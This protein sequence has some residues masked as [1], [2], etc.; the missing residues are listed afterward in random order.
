MPLDASARLQIARTDPQM[1]SW[2]F[3]GAP[4][5]EDSYLYQRL[6]GDFAK[7]EEMLLD[8]QVRGKI[9]ERTGALLGRS[10]LVDPAFKS[11]TDRKAADVARNLIDSNLIPY[12]RICAGFLTSGL[13]IGFAVQAVTGTEEKTVYLPLP[14]KEGA[15]EDAEPRLEKQKVIVPLLETVPQRRFTFRYHEPEQ[16]DV[17][18]AGGA[19]TTEAK[20]EY[21]LVNGYELRLL[22]RRAPV[23]GERCPADRF[24]VF[25][26]GSIK[27][28]PQGFGLGSMIRK[29]YEIRN[30][31]LRAGVLTGD[32][33]GSP[34]T[35]GTYPDT[36]DMRNPDHIDLVN[37][38]NRLLKAISPNAH[39]AT[40]EGFKITFLEPRS[41]GHMILKWLY[42]TSAQEITRAIWGEASYSEKDTGSYG[43]EAQQAQNRNENFVDADCNSLDEQLAAQYWRWIWSRNYPK[44]N[45]PIIRRE[46]FAERRKQAQEQQHEERRN[47][48][49]GTDRILLNDIGLEVSDGYIK[50]VYGEDFSLPKPEGDPTAELPPPAEGDFAESPGGSRLYG[51]WFKGRNT[52]HVAAASSRSRA[53]AAARASKCAG[54][55]Q[56]VVSARPLKGRSL[57]AAQAGRWVR[58]R[59]NGTE[60]GG[61]F[62]YRPHLSHAEGEVPQKYLSG[63]PADQKAEREAELKRRAKKP[64]YKPLPGDDQAATQP[65]SW[66]SR[67]KARYKIPLSDPDKIA[68]AVADAFPNATKAQIKQALA[69]SRKRGEAA[70][71]SGHRPGAPQAAWYRARW[72]SM[73]LG[74]E[75]DKDLQR[76]LKAGD[77]IKDQA[78]FA[79]DDPDLL[80]TY[81]TRLTAELA[82][83]YG[84]ALA[85]IEQFIEQ[86]ANSELE[87]AEKYRSFI[88]GIYGLELSPQQ[89]AAAL[90]GGL[91]AGYLAGA[92]S[93]RIDA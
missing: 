45:P 4:D 15:A 24:L 54:S 39:A 64:S 35:H 85:P 70:W 69:L 33:L 67:F 66:T 93:E 63:T 59:A 78:N 73:L 56:R 27:G 62:T 53:I 50:K 26:F 32:R 22:T 12:E 13:L 18:V 30:E 21:V 72:A 46:T 6:G 84:S 25:T 82:D 47:S 10:V 38:F 51:I 8:P 14:P 2:V 29:Y 7:Y 17:P 89:I 11:P 42:E 52:P 68:A 48:R 40:T 41:G 55:D 65:S 9:S 20:Q 34:P 28:L 88:D 71:G 80:D 49:A 77:P 87:E 86:I 92:Y 19:D 5:P 44:A 1:L 23:N 91:L 61:D 79:E 36:L 3:G 16:L 60:E 90:E 76:Q 58:E 81:E 43:A 57:K 83:S 75:A 74:G 31:C 37:S